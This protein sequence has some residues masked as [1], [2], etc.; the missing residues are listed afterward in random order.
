MPITVGSCR[1]L[2]VP[3]LSPMPPRKEEPGIAVAEAARTES[4]LFETKSPAGDEG[5]ALKDT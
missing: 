3:A 5:R 1:K 2:T 4:K